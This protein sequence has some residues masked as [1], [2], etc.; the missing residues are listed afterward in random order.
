M[1]LS[2]IGNICF[3]RGVLK[4]GMLCFWGKC[5]KNPETFFEVS[6]LCSEVPGALQILILM[7]VKR[8]DN[9]LFMKRLVQ[10]RLKM[11]KK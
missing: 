1:F 4:N 11:F 6:G 8:T 10:I 7:N 9:Q 3:L 2:L 5:I